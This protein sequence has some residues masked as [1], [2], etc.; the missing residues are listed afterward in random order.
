MAFLLDFSRNIGHRNSIKVRTFLKEAAVAFNVSRGGT[1]A[2]VLLY[3]NDGSTEIPFDYFSNARDFGAAVN[4]LP[5]RTGRNRI[6][7]S[8]LKAH[9]DLFGL[10][11]TARDYV[12]RIAIMLTD[13]VDRRSENYAALTEVALSIRNAG[14]HLLV[15]GIGDQI[16]ATQLLAVVEKRNDVIL[17]RSFDELMN[18]LEV[19]V[20]STCP[21]KGRQLHLIFVLSCLDY[22]SSLRN[23]T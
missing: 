23:I 11:G 17:P 12:P 18:H 19:C 4:L 15:I 3:S 16:N 8:Y 5:L 7:I 2:A 6:T 20:R 13:D 10:Y 21:L 1:R 9:E 14:V 22:V